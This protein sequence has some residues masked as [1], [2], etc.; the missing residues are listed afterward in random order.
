MQVRANG[1]LPTM[2]RNGEG[3]RA[4]GQPRFDERPVAVSQAPE[5]GE[6]TEVVLLEAGYDWDDLAK[7]KE[8]GAIGWPT[9]P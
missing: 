6:H 7:L 1:Y 2:T 4:G 9:T 8:S 3:G 5:H